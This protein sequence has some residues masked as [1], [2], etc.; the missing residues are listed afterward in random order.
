MAES[1]DVQADKPEIGP[2]STKKTYK[3]QGRDVPGEEI[4]IRNSNEVW[5]SYDLLD[6]TQIKAKFVVSAIAR[7]EEYK[8]SGDPVYIV[9]AQVV[10]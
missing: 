3:Y 4:E 10:L 8:E 5:S 1:P 9:N 2:S 7:L 6:G